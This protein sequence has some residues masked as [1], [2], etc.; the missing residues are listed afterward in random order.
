MMDP[1]Q[2]EV[3]VAVADEG[4]FTAAARRLHVVQSAVSSTIRDSCPGTGTG[5]PAVRPHDSPR[6]PSPGWRGVR[7]R[8]PCGAPGGG[9][10][11]GSGRRGE[12]ESCAA[13]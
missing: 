13:G 11:A 3:V 1:R 2:M 7:P 9:C 4:G 6:H 8:R 10:C 5:H 12:K